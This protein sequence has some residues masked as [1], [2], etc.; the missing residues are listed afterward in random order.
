MKEKIRLV[1]P[2]QGSFLDYPSNTGMCISLYFTG[3]DGYCTSCHNKKLQDYDYSENVIEI[4][5]EECINIIINECKRYRTNK[6][7]LMGGDPLYHKNIHFTRYLLEL[8]N[9]E[10]DICLYTGYNKD[11]VKHE[12]IKG[13]KYLKC[14]WY[15]EKLKQNSEKT[16][17]YFQLASSNQ[18]IYNSN[19]ILLSENGRFYYDV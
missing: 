3:C 1:L 12:N 10:Y 15:N 5:I 17:D 4:N 16:N 13:F 2:V 18:E 9:D 19:F 7:C 6:I 11:F 14:G 8:I